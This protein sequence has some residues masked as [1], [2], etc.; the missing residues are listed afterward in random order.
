[1]S[2]DKCLGNIDVEGKGGEGGEA[3]EDMAQHISFSH[4]VLVQIKMEK[5]CKESPGSD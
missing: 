4:K 1:M 5:V 2:C 3:L